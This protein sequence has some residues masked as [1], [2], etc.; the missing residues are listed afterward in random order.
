MML[1]SRCRL[2]V[3]P[4]FHLAPDWAA[5]LS[6]GAGVQESDGH[7]FPRGPWRPLTADELTSLTSVSEGCGE[8][9]LFQIPAHLS[10]AWWEL[11]ARS[12]EAAGSGL[13]GFEDFSRQIAEYLGFKGMEPPP[14]LQM[15]AVVTAAGRCSLRSDPETGVPTG[16][17]PSLAPW[18][19]CPLPPGGAVPRLWGLVNLGDEESRLVLIPIAV[20]AMMAGPDSPPGQLPPANVG[21]L[22]ERFL[23]EYPD[24]P[25][26]RLRLASGEG[27]RLPPGGLILD[28]D[29][30]DKSEADVLLLINEQPT[31]EDGRENS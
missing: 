2:G 30:T 13:Q 6:L 17:G 3:A 10:A 24:C 25:P 21:E 7:F 4:R 31:A 11:L 5:R 16:L 20:E 26:I 1:L 14:S 8:G 18:A 23:R 28:V 15:E 19:T 12:A 9:W 22:V 27:F 29:A